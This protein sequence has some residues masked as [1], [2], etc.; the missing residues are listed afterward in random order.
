MSNSN[1]LELVQDVHER[2]R[3]L[4]SVYVCVTIFGMATLP[5]PPPL[6][7]KV[8]SFFFT[9]IILQKP[10]KRFFKKLICKIWRRCKSRNK[11]TVHV[12]AGY[13]W[14]F[15]TGSTPIL[16]YTDRRATWTT[17]TRLLFS[18]FFPHFGHIR[19]PV[20]RNYLKTQKSRIFNWN[21]EKKLFGW[22]IVKFTDGWNGSILVCPSLSL[23]HGKRGVCLAPLDMQGRCCPKQL[24]D[25]K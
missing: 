18:I 20:E 2:N 5:N 8:S 12:H 24:I 7:K 3:I 19:I 25:T 13:R 1:P 4:S 14:M 15:K 23:G 9:Q 6:K 16:V 22:K 11:Y 17:T 10:P 21:K